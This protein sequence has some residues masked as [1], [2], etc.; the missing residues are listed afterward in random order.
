MAVASFAARPPEAAVDYLVSRTPHGRH[1]FDWRDVWEAEHQTSF[2]VAKMM[3]RDLLTDVHSALVAA[4][5]A[6]ETRESFIQRL[7]PIL[8]AKGWWGRQEAPDPETGEVREVQLGSSRR[9]GLIYD[10]NM[11]AAHAAARWER[12]Q[13]AKAALPYLVYTAVLDERTRH[14]HAQWGGRGGVRII[15]P[16]DH[17][18]WLTRYPP[19]GWRCRCT[20]LQMSAAML[21]ARGWS[22]TTDA[23]LA[24][25]KA[26]R[27]VMVPNTRRGTFDVVPVG[28]DPG[29]GYNVGMA[30]RAALTPPPAPEPWRDVVIGDRWPRA[31][32]PRPEPRPSDARRRPD[33][34]PDAAAE[35][36]ARLVGVELE[37]V[38]I[39]QAQMPLVIGRKLFQ[40]KNDQGEAVASKAGKDHRAEWVEALAEAIRNP[41]EIWIAVETE[42]GGGSRMVRRHLAVLQ[43]DEGPAYVVVAFSGRDRWD[44]ATTF[45]PHGG[46]AKAGRYVDR[47]VRVGTLVYQRKE[48]GRG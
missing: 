17:P 12:I 5:Q 33:L 43:T 29:F 39:D 31:L 41:D 32:P 38:F 20:V 22:V 16:V 18:F 36:L 46:A 13:E 8:K 35:E 23:Q 42:R 27:T 9:L 47:N 24:A 14:L 2:V 25:M 48:K 6:G 30:R 7:K 26:D 4:I 10:T 3:S 37:G 11:R 44:G 34:E 28:V 19:N 21:K 1:S 45:I 15:L 40:K